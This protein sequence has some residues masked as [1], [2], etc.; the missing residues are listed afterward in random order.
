MRGYARREHCLM[1]Q[2]Q[3]ALDDPDPVPCGRCGVCRGE[4]VVSVPDRDDERAEHVRQWMRSRVQ[5]V[6]PRKLWPSG[7]AG[8]KGRI[9][10]AEVGRAIAFADDPAWPAVIAEVAAST[11]GPESI[12]AAVKVLGQWRSDW[13]ARPTVVIALPEPSGAR[14]AAALA[15][16]IGEAGKLPVLEALEWRGGPI[17]GDAN[18]AARL[19]DLTGRLTLRREARVT[20]TVLLVA[21]SS[22]TGWTVTLAASLLRGAGAERVLPLVAHLQP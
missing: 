9:V 5:T 19:R 3:L 12:A 10:G 16:G 21:A 17:L 13:P 18:S 7:V 20:G 4:P 15:A 14:Y 1:Q 2:L 22:R 11:V 6:E 8:F